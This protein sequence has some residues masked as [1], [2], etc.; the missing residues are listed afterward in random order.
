[1]FDVCVLGGGPAGS[2]LALRLA[3]LGHSVAIVEKSPVP[4]SHIAESLAA[5]A[6]PL[7]DVIGLRHCI[8]NA[9]FVFSSA[10]T[11]RWAN[12][13]SRREH[14]AF[15]ADRGRFDAFLL[16]AAAH[17]GVTIR[18]L[19]QLKATRFDERNGWELQLCS[20]EL[21][22]ARYFANA[23]GRSCRIEGGPRKRTG[24]PALAMF[25]Y[26]GGLDIDGPEAF[27]E[28][29]AAHWYW[30][31]SLP[32]GPFLAC[33]FLDPKKA[34]ASRY[35]ALIRESKLLGARL[36]G[37][38][39]CGP[40]SICDATPFC[41]LHPINARS[42]QVGDAALAID[43]LSAQGTETAIGTAIHAAAAIHTMLNRPADASLAIDFYTKRVS[44]SARFHAAA[45]AAFY[46]RN[47]TAASFSPEAGAFWRKRAGPEV[48]HRDESTRPPL[49]WDQRIGLS[50]GV[51][52]VRIG[53]I[54]GDYVVEADALELNGVVS[55]YVAGFSIVDLVRDL[56][57]ENLTAGE[58]VGRWSRKMPA[59]SGC[60]L[61]QSLWQQGLFETIVLH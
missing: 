9:D 5:G 56:G 34:N 27:V 36:T 50:R 24:P 6:L 55:A 21:L 20:G 43:P 25:A 42:V 52:L 17:A 47:L 11:L 12:E 28:A 18:Q 53:A 59:A 19:D 49:L 7:L 32:G 35:E 39:V 33:V 16:N 4:R 15:Q 2:T 14:N 10:A 46:R 23:G 8:E 58:V 13:L 40:V 22:R 57:D 48:E 37:R 60:A 26:W 44:N 54:A 1:M 29:G 30:G 3:Q 38:A 61:L 41:C 51:S 45:A 31:T